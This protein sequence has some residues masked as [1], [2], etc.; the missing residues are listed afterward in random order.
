MPLEVGLLRALFK[1]AAL[2][3]VGIAIKVGALSQQDNISRTV[4]GQGCPQR[5]Y[6]DVYT[7]CPALCPA[8]SR[9]RNHEINLTLEKS[10]EQ[11]G[12]VAAGTVEIL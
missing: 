3:A 2:C 5:A 1:Q 11:A 10:P 12:T 4:C 6:M 8:D 9:R 7:A